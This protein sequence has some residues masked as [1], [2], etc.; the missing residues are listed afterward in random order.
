GATPE[1]LNQKL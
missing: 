1:D